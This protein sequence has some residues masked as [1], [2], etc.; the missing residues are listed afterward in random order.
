[1]RQSPF[2]LLFQP[3]RNF[4]VKLKA[5][6]SDPQDTVFICNIALNRCH[7]IFRRFYATRIQR[8]SQGAGESPGHPGN[9][10]IQGR[11]ILGSGYL[12]TVFVFVEM[13]DPPVDAEMDGV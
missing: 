8:A 7:Q 6:M 5:N 12:A 1:M 4:E 10:M 11:R 9:D 3:D 13:F 2:R